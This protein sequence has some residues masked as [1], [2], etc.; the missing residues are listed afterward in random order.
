[1]TTRAYAPNSVRGVDLQERTID[2]IASTFSLDSYNTRIDPNG[3]KL[4][5]FKTQ[6]RI[7]WAH[8]SHGM[9][10]SGGM[11]IAKAENV[12]VENG[13]LRM[14][15]RFPS[16][17][18]DEFGN[19]IFRMMAEGFIDAVS[20]GF[21][22]IKQ[23]R[24][25]EDGQDIIIYRE[26]ELV[27]TSVVSIPANTDAVAQRDAFAQRAK[28]LNRSP[29]ELMAA[30]EELEA[31]FRQKIGAEQAKR[32]AE[33]V[34][35]VLSMLEDCPAKELIL[36]H[37]SYF[38]QKQPVNKVASR[39]MGKFFK[40][41]LDTEPPTEEKE[42]WETVEQAVEAMEPTKIPVEQEEEA[43]EAPE[44]PTEAPEPE[45]APE[46]RA[47]PGRARR[48]RGGDPNRINPSGTGS[49]GARTESLRSDSSISVTGYPR[50]DGPLVH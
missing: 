1:M 13:Q 40:R 5:R 50:P 15:L 37:R 42:A 4:E 36:K 26:Q 32:Q 43:V 31:L 17:E 29:E 11:P 16:K 41:I 9:T 23:E 6:P 18:T 7:L 14:K 28:K 38:D 25:T 48:G 8:D 39:V 27:E 19:K 20:V 3:W 24:A 22:P 47:A 10:A 44:T 33:T 46:S 30:F 45:K 21:D 12:R 49:P 35:D 34:D 2:V